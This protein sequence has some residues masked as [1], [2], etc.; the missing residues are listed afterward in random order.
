M[1]APVTMA[2]GLT[3]F[4]F[5]LTVQAQP[6]TPAA[7]PPAAAP[8]VVKTVKPGLFMVTGAG[9]N[10]TVRTTSDGLVI[11][12]TKNNGQPIYDELMNRIR[13][14]SD[15]P[16]KWAIDT[17]HHADHTGNNARF[18]AAGVQVIGHKNLSLELAKFTPPANNPTAVAP[19]KPSLTYDTSYTIKQ[20][21]KTVEL[22]HYAPGHTGGDTLVWFPDLKVVSTG[23]EFVIRPTGANIDYPGGASVAGWVRSLDELLKL[24]WDTA[25]AGHGD[26]PYTR[27]DVVTFQGKLKTLLARAKEAVAAGAT[28]ETLMS[29]VKTDDLWGWPPTYWDPVRTAGLYAEAGG[30]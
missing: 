1:R 16:V 28:K 18:L 13:S 27:A 26:D 24:D 30:K 23:D 11:V 17:H 4:L 21:G 10:V 5:A 14:V 25:I 8:L 20:G 19:A 29:K 3:A 7:P 9:G 15:Q 22:R 2:A 6:P 12:D